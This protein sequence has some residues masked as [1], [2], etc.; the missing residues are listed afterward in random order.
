MGSGA[1]SKTVPGMGT[2]FRAAAAT[3]TL[4][5]VEVSRK[6]RAGLCGLPAFA[7]TLAN[8]LF[9]RTDCSH[10]KALNSIP[11]LP[12]FDEKYYSF[13]SK[14]RSKCFQ[15]QEETEDQGTLPSLLLLFDSP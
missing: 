3:P 4:S 15:L 11:H 14:K 10:F 6:A 9:S 1:L 5:V 13:S 12:A 8:G 7:Q 2:I